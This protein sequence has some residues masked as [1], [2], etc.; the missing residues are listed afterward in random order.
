MPRLAGCHPYNEL[1]FM[2]KPQQKI[3]KKVEKKGVLA[4][5]SGI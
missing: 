4:R 2:V 3:W 5:L 1:K